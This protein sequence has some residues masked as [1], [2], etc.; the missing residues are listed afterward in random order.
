[1]LGLESD[2]NVQTRL[3][4]LFMSVFEGLRSHNFSRNEVKAGSRM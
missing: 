4:C 2:E 3:I 1:M